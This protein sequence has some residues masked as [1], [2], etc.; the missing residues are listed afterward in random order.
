MLRTVEATQQAVSQ[1]LLDMAARSGVA[2]QRAWGAIAAW[3][4]LGSGGNVTSYSNETIAWSVST[5]GTDRQDA[6]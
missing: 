5:A 3:M 4:A 1:V 6:L 2:P